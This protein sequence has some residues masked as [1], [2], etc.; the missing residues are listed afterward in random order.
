MRYTLICLGFIACTE[1]EPP[2]DESDSYTDADGD[3]FGFGADCDDSDATVFPSAPELCDG[4]DNNCNGLVDDEPGENGVQGWSDSDGDGFGDP[5]T[6]V[7]TCDLAGLAAV[8]GDCDDGSDA[9]H[10]DAEEVCD[11]TDNDC[12]GQVDALDDDAVGLV[13]FYQDADGDG[14]GGE[15]ALMLCESMPGYV[16]NSDD[17]D[18]FDSAR[19]PS[20]IE[21]G[22]DG[23]DNNCDGSVDLNL[24]PRD[25]ATIEAAVAGLDDNETICLA[26][27]TYA[28]STDFTGRRFTVMG[29]GEVASVVLEV[30]SQGTVFIVDNWDDATDAPGDAL[31][32]LK[33]QNLTVSGSASVADDRLEGSFLRLRGGNASLREVA[34]DGVSL[35]AVDSVVA[36]GLVHAVGSALL[37]DSVTVSDLSYD[38]TSDADLGVIM[39]GFLQATNGSDLVMT[40][41]DFSGST[42]MSAASTG[43]SIVEGLELYVSESMVTMDTVNIADTQISLTGDTV[44]VDGAAF[45]G[46]ALTETAISNVSVRGVGVTGDASNEAVSYGVWVMGDLESGSMMSTIEIADNA[47]SQSVADGIAESLGVMTFLSSDGVMLSGLELHDNQLT[48]SRSASGNSAA[49]GAL[50]MIGV[51]GDFQYIDLRS[52]TVTADDEAF[53]GGLF[54]ADADGALNLTNAVLAGN[55]L[56]SNN[57]YAMGGGVALANGAGGAMVVTNVTIHGNSITAATEARGAGLAADITG[58]DALSVVNTA[59]GAS[60]AAGTPVEGEAVFVS[61]PSALTTWSYNAVLD[62]VEDVSF[63]GIADPTDDENGNITGNAFYADDTSE[64]PADWDFSYNNRSVLKN[65]GVPAISD[66]DESRSDIGS[67]GGPGSDGW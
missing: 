25:F 55:I 15:N 35:S 41:T 36:G 18:D 67:L 43:E 4:L 3:G 1:I 48:S 7:W 14:Y 46:W 38:L 17:C 8:G 39:G 33:I 54:V 45:A 12:D 20:F 60:V 22:C 9:I 13:T 23:L 66:A 58:L 24:V 31:G 6:G 28:E 44:V 64:D 52:N 62:I 21:V 57:G 16:D 63:Y 50:A 32:N 26:P 19:N 51:G 34:F 10:P 47:V 11:G 56:T 5:D 27:G 30:G 49:G 40:N 37:L 59:I 2:K 61:D 53:G 29:S 65:A 42:A